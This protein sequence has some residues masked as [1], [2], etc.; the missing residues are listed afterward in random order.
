MSHCHNRTSR[1]NFHWSRLIALQALY[2]TILNSQ[3][4][5][6]NCQV[7]SNLHIIQLVHMRWTRNVLPQLRHM[8]HIMKIWKVWR[9]CY[10]VG[11]SWKFRCQDG[12]N[13]R[14]KDSTSE[15]IFD[16]DI[17]NMVWESQSKFTL[18]KRGLL[19]DLEMLLSSEWYFDRRLRSTHVWIWMKDGYL[20]FILIKF[21]RN[22]AWSVIMNWRHA[23]CNVSLPRRKVVG[24]GYFDLVYI[25]V[26]VL[27]FQDVQLLYNY[28]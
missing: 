20:Y 5:F 9:Q 7:L 11:V 13:K 15:D 10:S 27:G 21:W 4:K 23:E 18:Y 1:N 16:F 24:S 17:K 6:F 19:W 25:G 14:R 3:W 26:L 12:A 22:D 2:F 8:K 28:S